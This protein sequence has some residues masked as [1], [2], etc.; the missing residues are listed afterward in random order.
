MVRTRVQVVEAIAVL[1]VAGFA[2]Q[3]TGRTSWWQWLLIGAVAAPVAVR[4]RWTRP[5]AVVTAAAAVA[6]LLTGVIE[7]YAAPALCAAVALTQF[8]GGVKGDV[9]ALVAGLAGGAVLMV[10]LPQAPLVAVPAVTVPWLVGWSVRQRRQRAEQ[11]TALAVT[12]ERLRIARDMH[13]TVAHSLS[14]IAMK[15]SIAR[16]LAAVRPEESLAALEVIETAGREALVEMRRAV[17]LLRADEDPAVPS[18][19]DEDLRALAR[20]TQQAG[21]AVAMTLAGTADPPPGVRLVVYRMVQEALTN[22]IRHAAA[23]RCTVDVEAGAD[24]VTVRISD[25]GTGQSSAATAGTR[26][27]PAS[28]AAADNGIPGGEGYGLRGMRER[29]NAYGGTL[30]TGTVP[31]GTP[32]TGAAPPDGGFHVNAR[33][34]YQQGGPA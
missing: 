4:S 13:D 26:A 31:T 30:R 33:I 18:G 19:S 27:A 28:L 32:Q 14:M 6:V 17:G 25:N 23:T 21:I 2:A 20:S 5:A 15:A 8:S 1:A 12:E 7:P 22:V 3:E 10:Q 11:R 9:P 24:A 34:P 16:H 29:I